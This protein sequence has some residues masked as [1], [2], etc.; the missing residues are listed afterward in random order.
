MRKQ[1]SKLG[2]QVW[3]IYGGYTADIRLTYS[4]HTA[5][6]PTSI[7]GVVGTVDNMRDKRYSYHNLMILNDFYIN[8][9]IFNSI[10]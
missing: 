2:D 1:L 10:M 9:T 3:L 6:N 8:I 4:G 5:D 7:S